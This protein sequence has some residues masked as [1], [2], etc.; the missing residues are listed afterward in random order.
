MKD[1]T[2]TVVG[3]AADAANARSTPAASRSVAAGIV[4]IHTHYDAQLPITAV[5]TPSATDGE[6][7]GSQVTC[8]S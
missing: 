7:V 6:S 3:R 2:I 1:G 5:V 8:A 4:D